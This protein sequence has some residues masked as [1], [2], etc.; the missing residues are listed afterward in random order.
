MIAAM[1]FLTEEKTL[2]GNVVGQIKV[3]AKQP[4]ITN[5][6]ANGRSDDAVGNACGWGS[7][8]FR[9]FWRRC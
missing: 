1:G 5:M 2:P 6:H 4:R 9:T 3:M 8:P 7:K